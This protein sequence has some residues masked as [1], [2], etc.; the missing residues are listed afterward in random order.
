MSHNRLNILT[1]CGG[2]KAVFREFADGRH[3]MEEASPGPVSSHYEGHAQ[4]ARAF[5][6]HPIPVIRKR[7]ERELASAEHLCW[8]LAQA[9][10]ASGIQVLQAT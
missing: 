3:N 10:R 6:N 9:R 5:L 1:E 4:A 8:V 2:D 7:A